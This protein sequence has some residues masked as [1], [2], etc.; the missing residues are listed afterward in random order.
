MEYGRSV[1]EDRTDGGTIKFNDVHNWNASSFQRVIIIIIIV[2][3]TII[4]IIKTSIVLFYY[5]LKLKLKAN[6]V[7][8]VNLGNQSGL[9]G[10]R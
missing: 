7:W 2:T 3:F 8:N 10:Y 4:N 9:K 5:Q 6:L 1:F